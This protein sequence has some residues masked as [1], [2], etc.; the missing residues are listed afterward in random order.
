MKKG[1]LLC[2]VFLLT[3]GFLSN[4]LAQEYTQWHLPEGATARLGKGKIKDVESSPDGNR[5]AVATDIGVWIYNAHT[6]AEIT[7]IKVQPRGIQTVN[8]IAFAPDGTTLAV[9]NWV[10][11]G[12][13]G[14]VELW[15]TTT[16][17]RLAV[18]EENIGS[19]HALEFSAD[20]TLLTSVGWAP[21]I[22][23]RMWEVTTGREVLNFT[24]AQDLIPHSKGALVL[25]QD[26]HSIASTDISTVR[27]W[28]VA[29]EGLRHILEGDR[30]LALTLAFSP[31]GKI[32]AGGF[33]TIR[34]WNAETGDELSK[35][36]GHTA[37]VYTITFS[38]D[39]K[40]L[41]SGDTSGKIILWDLDSRIQ[42]PDNKKSTLPGLLRSIT[43]DKLSKM[44]NERE[45]RTLV[46]HTLPIE[47]LD[48]TADSKMLV[49]GS[50][51]GAAIVWDAETGNPLFTITGHTGSVKALEFL[52]DNKTLISASSDGTLRIWETDTDNQQLIPMK[53]ERSIF[54]MALSADRK[55]VAIGGVGN[56][57][58]LWN[59][60]TKNFVAT[61]KTGHEDSVDTLAFSPD[62][63]IL[64]SGSRDRRVELWDVPNYQRLSILDSHTDGIRDMAFSA[65]GKKF[66]SASRDGT[67]HLWDL[68]TEKKTVLLTAPNSGVEALT[69]SPDS[70]MLVS[71]GWDGA[72]QLWDANTHQHITDFID[73]GEIVEALAFSP[74]GG[75]VVSGSHGGLIQLWDV[76][77]RALSHQIRTG[78]AASWPTRFIFTQDGRTLVSGDS[79][80]T[81][82]IWDL[83][84]IAQR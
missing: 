75:T 77:A 82:L 12:A 38:P 70:S 21:I 39:A 63:K 35:L 7:L 62:D 36:D 50:R 3:V 72:I 64:A 31:D 81:I 16:G 67:V 15:D 8:K 79:H 40:I 68:H 60:D 27:I 9:G 1:G 10:P 65:D 45:D 46:G 22:E 25:S 43:G 74:D 32:L 13:A 5:L 61:F 20:G 18:L 83:E 48:F 42:K 51:D 84:N 19:V 6:G 55:T 58:H 76:D 49:S 57:V 23:Y 53:H 69:F 56:D 52:E 73:A 33:E 37:L 44:E 30:N 41:A 66:A 24:K 26:T 29:T 80:G 4:N 34:L 47:A 78:D 2:I 59:A 54:C 17:E 14:A 11:G 28:D 71:A